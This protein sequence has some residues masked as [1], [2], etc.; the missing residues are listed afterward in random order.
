MALIPIETQTSP[1]LVYRFNH[2]T[3]VQVLLIVLLLQVQLEVVTTVTVPISDLQC[4]GSGFLDRN[5]SE[6]RI[7]A[8]GP[9]SSTQTVETDLCIDG[10]NIS[11]VLKLILGQ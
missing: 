1:P 4:E 3:E 7:L 2:A 10:P 5:G 9:C 11:T 8:Q 6:E